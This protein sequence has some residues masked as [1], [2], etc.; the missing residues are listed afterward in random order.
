MIDWLRFAPGFSPTSPTS[1]AINGVSAFGSG[2]NEHIILI[3]GTNFTCPCSGEI[4]AELGVDFIREIQIVSVG[5]SAEFGNMQG[6]VI[7]VITR[8]GS[9]RFLYD[10]SYYAQ[11][12]A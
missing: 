4:R 6:A 2:T 9:D 1:G 3:D 10:A 5:A 11:P 12:A 7:N 8:Q